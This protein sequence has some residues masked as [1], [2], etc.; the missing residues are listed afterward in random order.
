M[1]LQTD[2][3]TGPPRVTP[4]T[5]G[6]RHYQPPALRKHRIPAGAGTAPGKAVNR[7]VHSRP[8]TKSITSHPSFRSPAMARKQ[9]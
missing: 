7:Q 8:V 4:A 2:M 6:I 5:A 1:L 3:S 9:D